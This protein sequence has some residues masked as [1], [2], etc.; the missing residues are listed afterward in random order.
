MVHGA[1]CL[2]LEEGAVRFRLFLSIY[3]IPLKIFILLL[4]HLW[5][6]GMFKLHSHINV[7]HIIQLI[8]SA[9]NYSLGSEYQ[10]VFRE[11]EAHFAWFGWVYV[12]L[13]IFKS[14]FR[15]LGRKQ[16]I[17]R[18]FK[19]T[20]WGCLWITSESRK[21]L[22]SAVFSKYILTAAHTEKYMFLSSLQLFNTVCTFSNIIS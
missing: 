19:K 10:L 4:Y 1:E 13:L 6:L 14:H 15:C 16:Q 21:I 8:R 18:R 11:G 12:E 17:L 22:T 7:N 20:G 3:S 5:I 9:F 2:L